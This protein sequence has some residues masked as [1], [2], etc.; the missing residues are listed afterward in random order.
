MK[1]LQNGQWADVDLNEHFFDDKL[2]RFIIDILKKYGIYTI[3]DYGCGP[4]KYVA[5]F[6]KNQIDAIGYDGSPDT[7]KIANQYCFVKDLTEV[8]DEQKDAIMCLEVGEHIPEKFEHVLLNNI[9]K[10]A[11]KLVI[12]SWAI[13]GQ[14]GYG[15]INCKTNEYIIG[16]MAILGFKYNAD[17]SNE[18]RKKCSAFWFRNTFMVFEPAQ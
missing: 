5:E 16:R 14:D 15:H 7:T 3:A 9:A 2:C 13:P 6:N 4:G 12:L 11:R 18:G 10:N 17:L 1:T 8:I